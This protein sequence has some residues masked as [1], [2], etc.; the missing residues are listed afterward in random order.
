MNFNNYKKN[1][2]KMLNFVLKLEAEG[3]KM[4]QNFL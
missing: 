2:Q 4:P 3:R 1:K